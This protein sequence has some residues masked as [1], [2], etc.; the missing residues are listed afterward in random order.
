MTAEPSPFASE[1]W[2]EE[3]VEAYDR[4]RPSYPDPLFDDLIA[5]VEAGGRRTPVDAVEVGPGTGKATASLLA[6]GVR[7][8]A[9]EHGAQMSAFLRRK[10]ADD[11]R[12]TVINAPF[13]SAP[14]PDASFDTLVSATAFHWIDPAVR[15]EKAHR[16][17]RDGGAIGIIDTN[18]IA[19]PADRGFFDACFPI[20]LRYRPDEKNHA[21][22]GEDIVPGFF[23]EI[24]A[25][26]LFADV[27]LLRYRW[28]QTYPTAM[29]ADLVRSYGR[30]QTMPVNQR[31]A[32]IAD[33]SE[34]I[35]RDFDG[36]VVRP[37][38][39]TLVLGRAR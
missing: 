25:S 16:I 17:L 10:F 3:E 35:D 26:P 14:L 9:V 11:T 36:Y 31:E 34:L 30:S 21:T 29:Y 6:R 5:Y 39:I 13:E 18:Q 4:A 32:L 8:T 28:D 15:L 37:L 7:V 23:G 33:L 24:D 1:G 22:P 20:Y 38:V 2:F 19:S 27:R 12:L